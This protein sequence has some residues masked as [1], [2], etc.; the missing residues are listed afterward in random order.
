MEQVSGIQS[1]GNASPVIFKGK[2]LNEFSVNRL[3]FSV[4]A[5]TLDKGVIRLTLNNMLLIGDQLR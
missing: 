1:K 2:L 3:Q 5:L 4:L